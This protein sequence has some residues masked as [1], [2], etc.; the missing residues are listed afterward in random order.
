MFC[1]LVL[2]AYLTGQCLNGDIKIKIVVKKNFDKIS[3][4]VLSKLNFNQQKILIKLKLIKKFGA[5][6]VFIKIISL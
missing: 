6:W 1:V 2:A 4:I 3:K 5:I